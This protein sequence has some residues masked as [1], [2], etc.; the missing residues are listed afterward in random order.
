VGF[1]GGGVNA[2]VEDLRT[3]VAADASLIHHY[4][5]EGASDAERRADKK[6]TDDL[7]EVVTGAAGAITYGAAGFDATTEAVIPYGGG[8]ANVSRAFSTVSTIALP[9]T[10][11]VE[12][13]FRPDTVPCA[14][15][16]Y[17][18]MARSGTD[19][20]YFAYQGN[21]TGGSSD[22]ST[23]IGNPYDTDHQLIFSTLTG[24]HW[25]YLV[26]TF[27]ISGGSTTINTYI[28]DLT[29]GETTLTTAGKTVTGIYPA[30]AP[31]AIGTATW[32]GQ[33]AFETFEGAIDEV[34]LYNSVLDAATLQSHLN[35]I[36]GAASTPGTL[37]YGK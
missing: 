30:S 9:T 14:E 23:L 1:G 3:T 29:A 5:F 24:S 18:V 20:G 36:L 28:A 27:E 8:A 17:L 10:L 26:C 2:G 31:L 11:T 4:T 35:Q 7:S 33:P 34:A 22:M 19:R 6:G 21:T 15:R 12:V 13:L 37:I 32:T 16:G 25:Y